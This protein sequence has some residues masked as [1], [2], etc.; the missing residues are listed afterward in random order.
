[1]QG[2]EPRRRKRIKKLN[3]GVSMLQRKRR[4]NGF[5]EFRE[6]KGITVGT[7]STGGGLGV[8]VGE[9]EK[10][11]SGQRRA[12]KSEGG[13]GKAEHF[14]DRLPGNNGRRLTGGGAEDRGKRC[15]LLPHSRPHLVS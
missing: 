8:E 7:R 3:G 10:W 6:L 15:G 1:M 13:A 5:G 4:G 9:I 14:E 12:Q 2:N 11:S